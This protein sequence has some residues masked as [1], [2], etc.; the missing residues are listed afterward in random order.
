MPSEIPG[1][2]GR[3]RLEVADSNGTLA[4]YFSSVLDLVGTTN[5][6]VTSLVDL[7]VFGFC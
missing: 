2:G 4:T 5:L 1:G 7:S 3:S 6:G